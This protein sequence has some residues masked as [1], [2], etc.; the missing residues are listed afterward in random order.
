MNTA[1]NSVRFSGT[2]CRLVLDQ[3]KIKPLFHISRQNC[4]P[5]GMILS[6][7]NVCLPDNVL[8][9][10]VEIEMERAK[11]QV[12]SQD[13]IKQWMTTAREYLYEYFADLN[14]AVSGKSYNVRNSTLSNVPKDYDDKP[15][16][17][18]AAENYKFWTRTS[19]TAFKENITGLHRIN[20]DTQE[21]ELIFIANPSAEIQA[22]ADFS[23]TFTEPV[24]AAIQ[25][26][27]Q[28]RLDL[29]D[30]LQ[31]LAH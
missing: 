31:R 16:E 3:E 23:H 20:P 26:S 2:N 5:G 24:T 28:D 6:K 30:M 7:S 4:Y 14:T 17:G 13:T 1:M 29:L 11:G 8:L 21:H 15:L 9:G 18:Q 27:L 25:D 22:K 12:V 10:N 19:K